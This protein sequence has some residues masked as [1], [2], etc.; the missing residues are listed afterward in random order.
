MA[1]ATDDLD[2]VRALMRRAT[3]DEKHEESSTST[4]DALW[5]L[6]DRVLRVDPRAPR[7][8][9]RDRFILSKGHGPVALYAILAVK[10]FFPQDWLDRFMQHGSRLGSHPDRQLVPGVEA[11]TG[12]LGHGLP[13]AVGVAL[14]L[15]AKQLHEQRVFV[16]TGDAELNE[17]SNWE[18]VMVA[19]HLGLGGADAAR[20]RQPQLVAAD[21]P[22]VGA[23]RRVRL[24][25]A[26][27]RRPRPRR[28]GACAAHAPPVAAGRGRGGHP[29]GGVVMRGVPMREAYARHGARAV[30]RRRA[31]RDRAGRDQ[32][33]HA[34]RRPSAT[35]PTRAVNVGIAEQ[36]MVG[37]AAGF[38]LEGFHPIA[39]SLSPFMAERPYEQLK[40]DFGYQG[41]GG[42]F[43]GT[44]ASYDYASEGGTHH[45]PGDAA[46]LLAIPRMQVLAPGHGAEVAQLMRATY[47]NG[48]P[49]VPAHVAGRER[50]GLRRRARPHRGRCAT[51]PGRR[52]SPS[53]RCSTRTL[54]GRRPI[55]T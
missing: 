48:A 54:R 15:R 42:T 4:L 55:S 30:P 1:I 32:P 23:A 10:G 39:H 3:G 50:H 6:Y 12:S 11:S 33:R 7:A 44:G 26:R 35:T 20:D 14:A 19:P 18:A 8:E 16:L 37:V 38:A 22:V 5:V 41:L 43:I 45:S 21:G 40:L 52:S 25:R 17:G 34:A 2:T 29:A 27:G 47:A 53:A 51:A 28:A 13:M 46:A 36:T 31:R 49:D 9:E 24:G